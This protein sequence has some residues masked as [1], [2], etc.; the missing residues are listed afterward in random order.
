MSARKTFP[1]EDE[2]K[3]QYVSDD[4]KRKRGERATVENWQELRNLHTGLLSST[5]QGGRSR[6]AMLHRI[7]FLAHLHADK[8]AHDSGHI[9]QL[10]VLNHHSIHRDERVDNLIRCAL[11]SYGH[12]DS[13]E[14]PFEISPGAA[15]AYVESLTSSEIDAQQKIWDPSSVRA[16]EE[17]V[18][19]QE[20]RNSSPAIFSHPSA[21]FSFRGDGIDPD[22]ENEEKDVSRPSQWEMSHPHQLSFTPLS[23]HHHSGFHHRSTPY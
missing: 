8:D 9:P 15:R 20:V 16:S 18:S 22:E 5:Y 1:R 4:N 12:N 14:D 2:Y 3:K 13:W 19:Q 7:A 6:A 11:E 10:S 17:L 21:E 23:H